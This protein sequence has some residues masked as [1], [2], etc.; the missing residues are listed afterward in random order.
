MPVKCM[1]NPRRQAKVAK[2]IE[3]EVGNLLLT[4]K[5]L[6][7]AVCPEKRIGIDSAVSAIASVT[8]VSVSGDLTIAK[9]YLSIFSDEEGKN[10]A[11]SG[12]KKLQGYVRKHIA[13]S[14]NLRMAP[15]VRFL[16][17]DTIERAEQVYALL[18]RVKAER[19]D[20]E[21]ADVPQHQVNQAASTNSTTSDSENHSQNV[22]SHD[23]ILDDEG[24]IATLQLDATDSNTSPEQNLPSVRKVRFPGASQ[25]T[26]TLKLRKRS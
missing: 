8:E 7:K 23:I 25:R 24:D 2:Q 11:I 22:T 14:M 19:Q 18:D 12:L 9:V 17:D 3:R 21:V 5:V 1:A 13:T 10:I 4:D 20:H 6:Q 26:S 15:E 16:Q